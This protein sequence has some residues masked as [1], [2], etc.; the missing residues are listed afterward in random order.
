MTKVPF[1]MPFTSSIINISEDKGSLICGVIISENA[2]FIYTMC[3]FAVNANFFENR[4]L[5]INWEISYKT[6]SIII[7]GDCDGLVHVTLC[8]CVCVYRIT[9]IRDECGAIW[10]N[11]T[12]SWCA[13]FPHHSMGMPSAINR[14]YSD[15]RF[16]AFKC[17]KLNKWTTQR[18]MKKK[19]ENKFR[20]WD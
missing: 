6:A 19:N 10:C 4:K 3:N 9:V 17:G 11:E 15:S 1:E 12:A 2:G 18:N 8:P 16:F 5:Q 20:A 14:R 13:H 7:N